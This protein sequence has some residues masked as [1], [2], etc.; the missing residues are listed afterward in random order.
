MEDCGPSSLVEWNEK[1]FKYS[2]WILIVPTFC[3]CPVI[4]FPNLYTLK[5][6][7]NN[8][9]FLYLLCGVCSISAIIC[10]AKWVAYLLLEVVSMLRVESRRVRA[11][12]DCSRFAS[13]ICTPNH[14]VILRD[15][16]YLSRRTMRQSMELF[17]TTSDLIYITFSSPP[18]HVGPIGRL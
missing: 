1:A 17:A 18:C 5:K 11:L 3:V 15:G 6:L 9:R 12:L 10:L 13:C 7:S 4:Y 16:V 2:N 14:M 8:S